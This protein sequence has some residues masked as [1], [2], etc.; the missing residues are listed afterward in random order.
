M[1]IDVF[2]IHDVP[3]GVTDAWDQLQR[4]HPAYDSPYFRPEFVQ[5]V[6]RLRPH[7]Q[8][9]V[10]RQ[11]PQVVGIFPFER[12][13]RIG[14]PGGGRLS[15]YQAVIRLPDCRVCPREL[16]RA[17]GLSALDFDHLLVEQDEFAPFVHLT[18]QSPTL[19]L[20][21]G[22]AAYCQARAQ[23]GDGPLKVMQRKARKLARE[24]GPLRVVARSTDRQLL[25]QLMAWK[26]E[27]YQ[28]TQITDVFAFPWTVALLEQLLDGD[29]EPFG[30]M[31]SVL[32]AG[33]RVVAMH[34]GMRS[35]G[36]LHYWFPAYDTEYARYSPGYVLLL[37]VARFCGQLGL[38]KIDMGRG[39]STFKSDLMTGMTPVAAGSVD[40]RPVTR[41]VR[42]HWR[43]TQDWIRSS[44][45][46]PA[47][48]L[49]GRVLYR[50]RE[51][52][53]FR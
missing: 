2:D 40:L 32:Y 49:P 1:N 31:F 38:T 33:D 11:G 6:A 39:V 13:G 17:C 35:F 41:R 28:R 34:M 27:Q 48:R 44:P 22:F 50:C 42:E 15:D 14:R 8:V 16:V 29:S 4:M 23:L 45:L 53:S 19:D 26:S 12:H 25:H 37:E 21:G 20:R 7:V 36:V 18:D 5:A 30:G 52:A 3:P 47:A 24:V 51:W 46:R 43:R 10:I 9:A